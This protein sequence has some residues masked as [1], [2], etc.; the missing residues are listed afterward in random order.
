MKKIHPYHEFCLT[1]Q[2]THITFCTPG[3][4]SEKTVV[5]LHFILPEHLIDSEIK[6]KK[7]V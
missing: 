7:L 6:D 5:L 1:R 3:L 2:S 4:L